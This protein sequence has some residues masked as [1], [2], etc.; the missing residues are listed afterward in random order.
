MPG[1]ARTIGRVLE[2]IRAE[3]PDIS[4]SKLRY[5]ET[6]GLISPDRQQPSGYRRFSQDDVDRLLYVLRAQ[7]DRYL[8]LKVIR[9]E[10]EAL[11]RGETPA[12]LT[13]AE[14]EEPA[15]TEAKPQAAKPATGPG[16]MTR[17]QVLVESGLGE[18]SLIQL[19]RLKVIQPRRGSQLYGREAVALAVAA[20][21]LAGYGI[22][23]RQLRVLQQAA[24][25]E[26]AIVE[27]ALEPYRRRSGPPPEVVADLY[28]VVLQAHAALLHGQIH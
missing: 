13:A 12:T 18:A 23:L 14:G 11:D 1:A 24:T 7:R 21:K 5:L 10:L 27:Q 3:F 9:E 28:R 25:L 2:M 6:E 19:E 22:D 8:P 16:L 20:K 17:R 15:A 26:A 4:V